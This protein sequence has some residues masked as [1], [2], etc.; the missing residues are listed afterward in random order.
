MNPLLPKL[1]ALLFVHGEP[2]TIKKIANLLE[3]S[4]EKI[5]E[6]AQLL[7]QELEQ[8]KRGL[9]LIQNNNAL[10]LATKPELS[11]L[12]EKM[13]QGEFKAELT[14]ATLETLSIIAYNSPI[15]SADIEYIRG[16]NSTFILRAL[17]LRGL[18]TRKNN[19]YQVTFDLI[20]NLGL[21]DI[22]QLPDYQKY[23]DIKIVKDGS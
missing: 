22:T 10:Q 8:E 20:K 17:S 23:K 9:V 5:Q 19:L 12:V 7:K 1:E 18:I 2:L 4:E 14:P 16:V 6:N 21:T 3:T 13:V 15:S 11:P